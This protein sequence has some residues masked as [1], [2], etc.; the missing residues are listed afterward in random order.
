M[1]SLAQKSTFSKAKKR[2]EDQFR[3]VFGKNKMK[4]SSF[5]ETPDM[6]RK[7]SLDFGRMSGETKN[8]TIQRSK[9]THIQILKSGM[10]KYQFLLETCTPGTVP[11][12]QLVAAMLDLKAPVLARAAFLIECS[13][14]VHRC[15]RGQWPSWMRINFNFFRPSANLGL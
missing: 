6:S 3:F 1:N 15:N 11:D 5:E 4:Q 12:A 13:H 9:E 2:M 10:L 8:V 7:N 14:F